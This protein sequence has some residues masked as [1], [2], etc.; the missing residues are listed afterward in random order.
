VETSL[1][2]YIAIFVAPLS[3]T[4]SLT[5]PAQRYD[6][7]GDGSQAMLFSRGLCA[8]EAGFAFHQM[9]QGN[10]RFVEMLFADREGAFETHAWRELKKERMGIV[11][12][13]FL[14]HCLGLAEGNLK[15]K[16]DNKDYW[17]VMYQTMRLLMMAE[18]FGA[19]KPLVVYWEGAERD[20][21]LSIRKG[22]IS[23]DQLK[24]LFE[25]KKAH[26][27]A[28]KK[29]FNTEKKGDRKILSNWLIKI[30]QSFV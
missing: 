14:N 29:R 21:L 16:E 6:E 19:G 10:H 1:P 15:T 20:L 12:T 3:N 27:M 2:D 8:F 30:R 24:K 13:A 28:L 7:S 17:K 11:S 25:E 9:N 23:I 18:K 22:S 5:P 4:V 26:L